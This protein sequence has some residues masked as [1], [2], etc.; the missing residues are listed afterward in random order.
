MQCISYKSLTNHHRKAI[1]FVLENVIIQRQHH[2]EKKNATSKLD[3]GSLKEGKGAVV[4]IKSRRDA[5]KDKK[6]RDLKKLRMVY[7]RH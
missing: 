3:C 6:E 2:I 4:E 5:V 1:E 7:K